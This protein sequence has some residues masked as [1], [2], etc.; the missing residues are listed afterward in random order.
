M[1]DATPVGHHRPN[2][3][4]RLLIGLAIGVV[5]VAIAYALYYFLYAA[6]F[7]G[8]DD[9]YVGGDIVAITSRE[10][11]TILALHAD[12]TQAVRRGQLLVE[13]DPVTAKVALDAAEADL[14]R[15]VRSVRMNFSKVDQGRAQLDAARVAVATAESDYRRR[16]SAGQAVSAEE[17]NHARDTLT[18]ARAN[19]AVA[20]SDLAQA[21]ASV[22][23]TR[24]ATNPD[25]LAA[26]AKLRQ[27]A[28]VLGHMKLY[29]PVD[30]VIAQRSAQLLQ[31]V[32]PG[33]PLMAVVPLQDVWIDANFKEGQLS[34][35]RIGQKVTVT[36]DLYGGSVTYHGHVQGLGAGSGSAFA[37]LP[38]QNA[39]GNW[40]KIVQRV[41]VRI[42]LDPKELRDHPLRVGLSVDVS[43]DISDT[44]GSAMGSTTPARN[45]QGVANDGGG[46]QLDALIERILR[47]N[48]A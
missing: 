15:V 18:S 29:A 25:V 3:R 30:G 22:S 20:Q 4:R 23:N 35:M 43:V 40:I 16:A 34:D 41:P 11:G 26:I 45:M 1:S 6:H 37:L 17:L 31:Q 28:I 38:P 12:N 39:S 9:A 24:V 19:V 47:Q 13:L 42:A 14:A 8:T 7:E 27:A 46:P 44:S 5:V 36:A 21:Q 10:P 33:T 2:P 32:A 48:G